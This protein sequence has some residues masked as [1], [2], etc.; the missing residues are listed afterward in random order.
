MNRTLRAAALLIL[1][2]TAAQADD[3]ATVRYRR[4]RGA[5]VMATY[6][7]IGERSFAVV[8]FEGRQLSFETGPT[9]SG[10][11]YVSTDAA[12]PFVWWTKGPEAALS[13]GADEN[14]AAIYSDCKQ[15]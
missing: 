4:D 10:A 15:S 8:T 5:E 3:F 1:G 13:V 9:G 11:R 12:Q 6:L 7:N 14:E 2:S